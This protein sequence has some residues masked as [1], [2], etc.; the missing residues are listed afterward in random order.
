MIGQQC[1]PGCAHSELAVGWALHALE[2]AEEILVAAHLRGCSECARTIAE[3]ELVGAV[4]G[5]SLPE[6]IPSSE[7]EQRVRAVVTIDQ[8]SSALPMPPETGRSPRPPPVPPPWGAPRRGR[9]PESLCEPGALFLISVALVV[10]G[11][12]FAILF[13]AIP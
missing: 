13:Y 1:A 6:A 12:T 3:T 5:L 8:V 10:F 11:V 4:V 7:L 2:P 9:G